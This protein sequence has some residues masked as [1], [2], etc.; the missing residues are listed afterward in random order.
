MCK[1]VNLTT[2]GITAPVALLKKTT[3]KKQKKKQDYIKPKQIN[4]HKTKQTNK[5]KKEPKICYCESCSICYI[6]YQLDPRLAENLF[7]Y[8]T[9]KRNFKNQK[10]ALIY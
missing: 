1:S 3:T 5:H 6:C 4:T 7:V 2:H 8:K 10:S 9:L